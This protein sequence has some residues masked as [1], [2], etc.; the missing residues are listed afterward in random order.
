M[1]AFVYKIGLF[2][3]KWF[4]QEML[5]KLVKKTKQLYAIPTLVE[6]NFVTTSFYLWMSK[7]EHDIFAFVINFFR[8]D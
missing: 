1:F 3:R 5:P 4:S 7:G 8:N 2:S 6:C